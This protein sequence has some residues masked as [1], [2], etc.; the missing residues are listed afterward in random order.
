MP[1]FCVARRGYAVVM[2]AW[3]ITTC[4]LQAKVERLSPI[5]A[6]PFLERDQFSTVVADPARGRIIAGTEMGDLRVYD[7]LSGRWIPDPVTGQPYRIG[8]QIREA[9]ICGPWLYLRAA[10]LCRVDLATLSVDRSYLPT[11][12]WSRF[13]S[14]GRLELTFD[15]AR[16]LPTSNETSLR[17]LSTAKGYLYDATASGSLTLRNRQRNRDSN[18]TRIELAHA[19]T[20][21]LISE[22]LMGKDSSVGGR[23]SPDGKIAAISSFEAG[24]VSFF[25]AK[26][27][28]QFGK[29][30]LSTLS[31]KFSPDSKWLIGMSQYGSTLVRLRDRRI[32]APDV[33]SAIDAAFDTERGVFAIASKRRLTA[34]RLP[35]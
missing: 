21:R 19:Y 9:T 2:I 8:G 12:Q 29:V 32:F 3:V 14:D 18:G 11:S 23:F 17:P 1:I 24:V 26:S 16:F 7:A 10:G 31:I 5:W 15:T 30:R 25:H 34:F 20:N 13:S 35:R 33:D 28:K 6:T 22:I 27:G 4:L